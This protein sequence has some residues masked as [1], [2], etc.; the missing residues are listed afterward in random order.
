MLDEENKQQSVSGEQ[1][2]VDNNQYIDAI[3]SLKENTVERSKYEELKA[4]NKRLLESIVNGEEIEVEAK[5][6][7]TVQSLR[8]DLFKENSGLSNLEYA[9][10]ALELREKLI[11]EG[12]PDPFVPIGSQYTP[13]AEDEAAAQRVADVLKTCIEYAEGDNQIFTNELQRRMIDTKF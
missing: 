1:T 8:N 2:E 5:D 9:E 4:E 7:N 6:V 10:K 12:K 11:S 13:T 3:K